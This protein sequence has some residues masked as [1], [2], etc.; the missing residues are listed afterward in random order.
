VREQVWQTFFEKEM[1]EFA[2]S[3]QTDERGTLRTELAEGGREKKWRNNSWLGDNVKSSST[4]IRGIKGEQEAEGDNS[5][6]RE[7][8]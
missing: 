2:K 1:V 6:G 8:W 4:I 5:R 3:R 7:G